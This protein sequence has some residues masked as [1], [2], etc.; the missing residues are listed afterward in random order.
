LVHDS[1][2][3][4]VPVLPVR[5]GAGFPGRCGNQP[6]GGPDMG[7][8]FLAASTTTKSGSSL[9]PFLIIAVLFGLFYFLMIRPQRNRQRAAAQ[10]QSTVTPGQ[11]V[12]TTA[13]IYGT[14][15]S[16]DDR[17]VVVQI[18]PG[19]EIRMLRR[20]VMEV[21]PEDDPADG[22]ESPPESHSGDNTAG[23]W[24]TPDRNI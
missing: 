4:L 18:A 11:R 22:T 7:K 13:G 1:R 6:E 21:L 23:D 5:A 2:L 17:D 8:M 19:V 24:D 10:M 12:R 20:A 9:L 15:V 16:A 3:V 14:I